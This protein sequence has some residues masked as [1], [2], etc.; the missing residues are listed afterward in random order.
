MTKLFTF[1]FL[2]ELQSKYEDSSELDNYMKNGMS[3]H[4]AILLLSEKVSLC[5][6]Y[7]DKNYKISEEGKNQTKQLLHELNALKNETSDQDS[8]RS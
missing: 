2:Q 7:I 6:V 4:D 8:E 3:F 5:P 1:E